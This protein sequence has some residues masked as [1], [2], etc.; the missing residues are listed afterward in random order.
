MKSYIDHLNTSKKY[1]IAYLMTL[2]KP[3]IL[4]SNYGCE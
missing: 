2:Q 1:Q 4:Y 3:D